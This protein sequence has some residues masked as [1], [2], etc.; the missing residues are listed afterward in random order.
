MYARGIT[1]REIQGFL[2]EQYGTEVPQELISSVTEDVMSEVTA[3]QTRA[4]ESMYA[5]V[6]FDAP[7]GEDS[8]GRSG[9]QQGHLPSDGC[10]PGRH[11]KR[12]EP[13]DRK[14]WAPSSG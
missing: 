2:A 14:H 3:W 1:V 7:T 10:A 11:T 13:V 8:R 12:P 6:F 5:V 9:A 4:F